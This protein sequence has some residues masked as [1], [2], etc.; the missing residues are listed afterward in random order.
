MRCALQGAG[1]DASKKSLTESKPGQLFVEFPL[2][3]LQPRQIAG[4]AV[5]PLEPVP[6]A[7]ASQ[8]FDCPLYKTLDRRG[9]LSTTGHSTNFVM[10]IKVSFSR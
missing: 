8:Q 10:T 7:L 6:A 9:Q 2:V 1:W 5:A 3:A 4:S